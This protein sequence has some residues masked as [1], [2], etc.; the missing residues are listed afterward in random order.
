MELFGIFIVIL[1]MRL[2]F[3]IIFC[4]IATMSVFS[5]Q[6]QNN[7]KLLL[8]KWVGTIEETRSGN[9]KL[10]GGRDRKELGVYEFKQN[11]IVVDNT[12]SPSKTEYKY[13]LKGSILYLGSLKFKIEKINSSELVMIDYDEKDPNNPLAFRH[14]FKKD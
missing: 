1:K 5:F 12:L 7:Q 10:K 4:V 6:A 2:R 14:Y 3:K 13:I 8:G 11:G 9:R